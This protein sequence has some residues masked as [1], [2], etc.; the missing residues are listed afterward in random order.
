MAGVFRKPQYTEPPRV[1]CHISKMDDGAVRLWIRNCPANW[2]QKV[3]AGL[4]A[5]SV[6]HAIQWAKKHD[7]VER[8]DYYNTYIEVLMQ[9]FGWT[10]DTDF[11]RIAVQ[12]QFRMIQGCIVEWVDVRRFLNMKVWHRT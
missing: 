7:L 4:L 10:D 12:S 8:S 2:C 11:L 6:A 1:F 5:V 9:G 3:C